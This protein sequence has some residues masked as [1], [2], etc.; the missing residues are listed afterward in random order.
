MMDVNDLTIKVYEDG[1]E[2]EKMRAASQQAFVKGFTTN[3]S[4]LKQAGV[5]DYL[6]FAR[7]AVAEFPEQEFSFEVFSNEPQ[8]MLREAQI[9]H[10]LG[11]RV[12]VKVP[13]VTTT[14]ES[15]ADVI[16]ELSAAHINLNITAITT[17][18]QVEVAERNLAPGTHNL[19]SIFVGR[20]A[21]A[22]IDPHHLIES[23]VEITKSHPEASLLWAS[24][25][26]VYNVFEAQQMGVDIITVPP[27]LITKLS[28]TGKAAL[29]ISV[30][31]VKGFQRD[32]EESGLSIL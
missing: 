7:Q 18:E 13:I 31:T 6:A 17:V 14:G 20:V 30:D 25:R 19:I 22:G 26:E 28:K 23:S 5:T 24:T 1:A 3:P 27:A 29:E 32:I 21:D 9:L 2:I 11:P 10:D 15:T 8:E 4:L 12:Y 16:K